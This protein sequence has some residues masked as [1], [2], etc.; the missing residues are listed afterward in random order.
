MDKAQEKIAVDISGEISF[1]LGLL[2]GEFGELF[3]NYPDNFNRIMLELGRMMADKGY[4][5][6]PEGK[7][8]LLSDEEIAKA[9]YPPE[10]P[11]VITENDRRIAQAQ[12]DSDI[13]W[14]GGDR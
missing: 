4:H 9:L 12:R 11:D 2:I 8:P 7:P 1:K 6:L 3:D 14:Y 5:K 10:P 13:R